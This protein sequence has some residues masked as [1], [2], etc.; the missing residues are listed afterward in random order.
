MARMIDAKELSHRLCNGFISHDGY[1]DGEFVDVFRDNGFEL[2]A[3]NGD[4]DCMR[5]MEQVI[6]IVESMPEVDAEPARMQKPLTLEEA[7]D[8]KEPGVC[9]EHK[10]PRCIYYAFVS[11][12]EFEG[13]CNIESIGRSTPCIARI[14]DY[15]KEWRCWATKPSDAERTAAAWEE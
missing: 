1:V 7:M 10:V 2:F 9:V 11:D 5:F 15:G 4:N 6:R 12:S 3:N 14:A 8:G 13:M